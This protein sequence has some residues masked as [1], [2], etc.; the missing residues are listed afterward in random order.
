VAWFDRM[1]TSRQIVLGI[2]TLVA[3]QVVCSVLILQHFETVDGGAIALVAVPALA[4]VAVAGLAVRVSNRVTRSLKIMSRVLGAVARG[5]LSLGV[6]MPAKEDEMSGILRRLDRAQTGMRKLLTE[7]DATATALTGTASQLSAVTDRVSDGATQVNSRSTDAAGRAQQVSEYVSTVATTS[8]HM[9]GMITEMAA[10]ASDGTQVAE[11][12]VR[13]AEATN[14]MVARLGESS[15]EI[16]EVVQVITSI[17]G[18]TNLLALNATI[19]A[20]R[21]GEAGR[22]FAVVA[23]EVKELAQETAKATDDITRRMAA[24]Q[25]DSNGV[26]EAITEISAIIEQLNNHQSVI[27]DALGEHT[28]HSREVGHKVDAAVA[29]ASVIAGDLAQMT[30]ITAESATASAGGRELTAELVGL[31]QG[32]TRAVGQF[33]L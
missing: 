27:A 8:Q 10:N 13:V 5:D 9:R 28:S 1:K 29:D 21:A 23:G 31:A 19:E 6:T 24:V 30:A 4:M 33:T 16:G 26:I 7:V 32:L 12:A 15:K 14:A 20:A 3:V 17:A 22:G 2:A 18:Q 11:R 25:T